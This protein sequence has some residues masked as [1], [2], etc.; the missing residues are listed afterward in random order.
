MPALLLTF[1][2][3]TQTMLVE[4]NPGGGEPDHRPLCRLDRQHAGPARAR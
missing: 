4:S 3:R 1:L 2:S